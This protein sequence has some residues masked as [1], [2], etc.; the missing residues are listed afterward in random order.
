MSHPGEQLERLCS[1]GRQNVLLVA[2]FVKRAALERLLGRVP[3]GVEVG[4]VTRWRPDEIVAG[5]SDLEVWPLL[6]E[7]PG[8]TLWLR[9]DLHAKY[10]RA[11]GRC[12]VG[13]ANL[14]GAALGWSARPNLE[15]LVELEATTPACVAFERDLLGGAIPVDDEL[16][17]QLTVAVAALETERPPLAAVEAAE[18]DGDHHFAPPLPPR[19]WLPSL[20]HPEDLYLAYSGRGEELGSA[21]Q[22]SAAVDLAALGIGRGLSRGAF[23]ASV[24]AL[25]LQQPIICGVDQLLVQPQRFGAV[26]T[27]LRASPAGQAE[28]FDPNRTWQTLMRWLLHFLPSRYIRVPARHSEVMV[29][30]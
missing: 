5:V 17:G 28:D 10:Y 21:A 27:H 18:D 24:G 2:P 14:T 19:P 26:T 13:S 6:R 25:L 20:R 22:A 30:R 3:E 15:L 11:D 8:A 4:C 29:R 9:G 23:E 7:R 16:H 1:E 12:L